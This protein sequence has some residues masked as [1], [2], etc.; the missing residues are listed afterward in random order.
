MNEINDC[1]KCTHFE[2]EIDGSWCRL[3]SKELESNGKHWP[4]TAYP[5]PDDCPILVEA[6]A[7]PFNFGYVVVLKETDKAILVTDETAN[8]WVPKSVIHDN[9]EVWKTHQTGDLVVTE[10]F[11]EKQGWL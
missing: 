1:S 5:V 9:S 8:W 3:K 7:D 11:A 6:P 2:E 4:D 10:R